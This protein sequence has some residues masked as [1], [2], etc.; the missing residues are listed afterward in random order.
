[1]LT[2]GEIVGRLGRERRVEQIVLR[3]AGTSALSADLKDLCQMIYTSLLDYPQDKLNDL[4][5]SDAINFLI[6]RLVL[7]NLRSKTSRYYYTIK[8]FSVRSTDLGA[9]EYK[10]EDERS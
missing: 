9:V 6:V 4:W 5:E 8:I 7:F 1:M 3:I 10:T 2:V